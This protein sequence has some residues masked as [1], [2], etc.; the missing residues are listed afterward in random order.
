MFVYQSPWGTKYNLLTIEAVRDVSNKVKPGFFRAKE[1]YNPTWWEKH[2]WGRK[3]KISGRFY[4]KWDHNEHTTEEA[5]FGPYMC[6]VWFNSSDYPKEFE[7]DTQ[8]EFEEF[9][10]AYSSIKLCKFKE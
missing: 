6:Y 7:F 8:K 4:D 10:G 5:C 1:G 9:M 3:P 2:F